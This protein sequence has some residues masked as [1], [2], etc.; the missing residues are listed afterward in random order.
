MLQ[1]RE[2]KNYNLQDFSSLI[3]SYPI[4]LALAPTMDDDI[5]KFI[6]LQLS[7]LHD[8]GSLTAIINRYM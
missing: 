1:S 6:N 8:S 4:Y 2:L 5:Q 7:Q 3:P